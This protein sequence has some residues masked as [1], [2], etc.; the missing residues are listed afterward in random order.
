MDLS[1]NCVVWSQY[2][3][4]VPFD[5]LAKSMF[6]GF[7]VCFIPTSSTCSSLG[8]GIHSDYPSRRT[9]SVRIFF[10]GL[11]IKPRALC[12]LGE[13][14]PT[15]LHPQPIFV[16]LL[17]LFW[18]CFTFF[19]LSFFFFETSFHYGAQS[20][21]RFAITLPWLSRCCNC[22][23]APPGPG[24]SLNLHLSR[25]QLPCSQVRTV[26]R[27]DPPLRIP[28]GIDPTLSSVGFWLTL[29]TYGTSF[30]LILPFYCLTSIP[31]D[32]PW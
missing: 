7:Q 13:F 28:Y 24:V 20:D 6:T 8:S 18:L 1:R 5:L 4:H 17:L 30:L 27:S 3:T 32:I 25:E 23:C 10:P 22:R 9:G 14:S 21:L 11:G 19:F 29:C 2:P 12:I 31:R 15:E 26:L 16:C